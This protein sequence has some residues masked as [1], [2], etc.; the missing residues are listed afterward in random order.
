MNRK[1][2]V[3]FL[4]EGTAATPSPYPT[5]PTGSGTIDKD[6]VHTVD[7]HQYSHPFLC[8]SSENIRGASIQSIRDEDSQLD[9]DILFHNLFFK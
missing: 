4:G 7:G 6:T 8:A 9:V 2:H 3:P 1:V 5:P